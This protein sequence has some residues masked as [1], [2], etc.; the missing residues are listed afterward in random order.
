[1]SKVDLR[2]GPFQKT[3]PAA[4]QDIV[5]HINTF[6]VVESHYRRKDCSFEFLPDGLNKSRMY[7]LYIDWCNENGKTPQNQWLYFSIFDTQLNLKFNRP[8]Q[9]CM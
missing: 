6:D 7:R 2:G 4:E 9:R 8:L 5:N 1:M 3:D